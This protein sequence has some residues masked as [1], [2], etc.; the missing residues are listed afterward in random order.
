MSHLLISKYALRS[1]RYQNSTMIDIC[2]IQLIGTRLE[3]EGLIINLSKEYYQQ[4]IIEKSRA[5]ELLKICSIANLVGKQIV[6][7]ALELGLA[8]RVSVKMIAGVP[9]LMIYKF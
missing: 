3:Q 4:E 9:F 1:A 5:R 6:E 7:L 8:K 2:D